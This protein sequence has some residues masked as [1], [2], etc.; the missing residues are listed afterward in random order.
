MCG[1]RTRPN[2]FNLALDKGDRFYETKYERRLGIENSGLPK[3]RNPHGN[4]SAI[5]G[6]RLRKISSSYHRPNML[7]SSF[8]HCQQTKVLYNSF[9][10]PK[11]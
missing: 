9:A 11:R 10:S 5:L 2:Q 1:S 7:S 4:G 3:G 8:Y 6:K